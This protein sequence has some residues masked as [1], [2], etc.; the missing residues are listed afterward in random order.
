M[1][2]EWKIIC[3][4]PSYEISNDGLIRR[5]STKKI[6]SQT[7]DKSKLC[8][9]YERYTVTLQERINGARKSKRCKVHRLVCLAFVPNPENKNEVDHIDGNPLNNHYTNLRW[10]TRTE[11]MC[12]TQKPKNNTSGVKGVTWK[13]D[14]EKWKAYCSLNNKQYHFGYYNNREDAEKAVIEGRAKLHNDFSRHK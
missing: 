11:Q 8:Q 5:K 2:R 14:K 6:I 1:N 13:K 7:L 10:A 12:N 9:S 3:D 4:Y